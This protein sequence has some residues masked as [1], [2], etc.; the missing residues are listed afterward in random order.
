MKHEAIPVM[1]DNT[2]STEFKDN[3]YNQVFDIW[4]NPEIERRKRAGSIPQ[5]FVPWAIQI[6]MDMDGTEQVRL[7]EEVQGALRRRPNSD[8]PDSGTINIAEFHTIVSEIEGFELTDK[9][10]PN[11]G[12]ITLIRHLRG[13]FIAFD[14]RYNAERIGEHILA[15]REYLD[16]ATMALDKRI[17]RPFIANLHIATELS[18]KALLLTHPD[19]ELLKSKKHNMTQG[20]Y[21]LYAK[22]GN[23][24]QRFAQLL[25]RLADL[26]NPARYPSGR[27]QIDENEAG[28][29]LNTAEDMYKTLLAKAPSRALKMLTKPGI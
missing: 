21:N 22:Q 27:F 4:A 5:N 8:I 10:P 17:I 26:R 15:A 13:F 1:T 14:L 29:M 19:K 25:N 6:I 3:L 7:N 18:A 12:H 20:K 9:D 23:T 28:E 24:E 16:M 2:F 11:A